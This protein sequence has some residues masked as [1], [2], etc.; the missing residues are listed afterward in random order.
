[1]VDLVNFHSKHE[2]DLEKEDAQD[3]EPVSRQP[4]MA[5]MESK[6]SGLLTGWFGKRLSFERGRSIDRRKS[7]DKRKSMDT[8]KSVDKRKSFDFR[9]SLDRCEVLL[10]G[11]TGL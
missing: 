4:S 8:R 1:M 3:T 9:K 7:M 6:G 2:G 10:I 11:D 5:R